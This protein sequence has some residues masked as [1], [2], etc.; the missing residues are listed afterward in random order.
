M[1]KYEKGVFKIWEKWNPDGG[2]ESE[3]EGFI[4]EYHPSVVQMTKKVNDLVQ[5]IIY[6]IELMDTKKREKF[7]EDSVYRSWDMVDNFGE[8][9][10][11]DFCDSLIRRTLWGIIIGDGGSSI[12]NGEEIPDLYWKGESKF[13]MNVKDF[14]DDIDKKSLTELTE[15]VDNLIKNLEN[16]KDL[17]GSMDDYQ[18]ILKINNFIQKKF[19]IASKDISEK[20]KKKIKKLEKNKK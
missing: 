8:D 12:I 6:G 18:K 17:D 19:Q 2:N 10:A 13:N 11:K 16:K 7:I 15:L 4:S 9:F 5:S 14:L 20:S 3:L 1:G